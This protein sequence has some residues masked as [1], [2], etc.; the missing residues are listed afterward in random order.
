M[1][2]SKN[3]RYTN[4]IILTTSDSQNFKIIPASVNIA[5]TLVFEF[6]NE[7]TKIIYTKYTIYNYYN[8]LLDVLIDISDFAQ[9]NTFY[10]LKVYL[11]D[12]IFVTLYKD[13]VF[14]TNQDIN[15]YS[16][17]EGQYVTPTID[18]NSYITI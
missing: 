16:I 9:E 1:Q 10:N 3:L 15:T 5:N 8:D 14:V 4:M 17:N 11:A 18:N 12:D 7:I 2:N 13:K 6:T